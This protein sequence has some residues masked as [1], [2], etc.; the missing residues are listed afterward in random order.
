MIHGVMPRPE[1]RVSSELTSFV[2]VPSCSRYRVRFD[3]GSISGMRPLREARNFALVGAAGSSV[4][5]HQRFISPHHHVECRSH[6]RASAVQMF[7]S[8]SSLRGIDFYG[9]G[10]VFARVSAAEAVASNSPISSAVQ[11]CRNWSVLTG[12][13]V[14]SVL[15][16]KRP[17]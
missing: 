4:P 16:A 1:N 15:R 7:G 6:G 2:T 12:R 14:S 3:G 13:Q 10:G 9:V 5:R 8:D 11:S 17:L